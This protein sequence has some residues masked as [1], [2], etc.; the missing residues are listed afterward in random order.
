M[1][2][3]I[4]THSENALPI[5]LLLAV[6][7]GIPLAIVDYLLIGHLS[8]F[9]RLPILVAVFALAFLAISRTFKIFRESDFA[10]LKDALP[11]RVHPQLR[12]IEH[13]I[14]GKQNDRA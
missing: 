13:L 1:G 12:T 4:K 3:S 6:G 8:P 7:V 9:R 11:H 5:A 14:V 10:I 2:H